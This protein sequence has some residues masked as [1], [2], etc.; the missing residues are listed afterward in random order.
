MAEKLMSLE[1]P[2]GLKNNGTV[3]ESK[4][5]WFSGNLVRF[6]NG[7]K[8]PVGGWVRRTLTGAT[9]TGTPKAA[10]SWQLNDGTK[11]IA[12]GTTTGLFLVDGDNVVSDITPTV[13]YEL[14]GHD[15]D[16]QLDNFGA[17]LVAVQNGE[18]TNPSGFVNGYYWTGD[19]SVPAVQFSTSVL[20][21]PF[22]FFGVVVTPERFLFVLRGS[23][24]LVLGGGTIRQ[25]RASLSGSIATAMVD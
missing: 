12:I 19:V 25:F 13:G 24:P 16:W 6:F 9:I 23:D 4:D 10:H 3:L 5:R 7:T 2:P 21:C 22:R 11:Y 18:N 8:Q 1:L 17:Y 20:D 14:D 15:A